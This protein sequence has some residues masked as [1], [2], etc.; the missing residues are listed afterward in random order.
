LLIDEQEVIDRE[1]ARDFGQMRHDED[2]SAPV[3]DLPRA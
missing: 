1:R 2:L 3:N